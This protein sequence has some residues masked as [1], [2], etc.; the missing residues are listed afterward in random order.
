MKALMNRILK[1][2]LLGVMFIV[3]L[4]AVWELSGVLEWE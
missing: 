1:S 4:L 2:P 3:L